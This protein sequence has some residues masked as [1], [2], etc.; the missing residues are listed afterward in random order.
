MIVYAVICRAKDATVLAEHS[1]DS[2]M[3]GNGP[4]VTIALLQHLKDHPDIVKDGELKTFVHNNEEGVE[5]FF[6][7]FL[8]VC[9]MNFEDDILDEYYFHLFLKDGVFYCCISDDPDTR[10]QKVN[11]A[12][13]QQIHTEFA[14]ANRLRRISN[15]NAYAMDKSFAPNFRTAL[16]YY[17]V[18][19][20]KLCQEEK[21]C[22]ILAQVEDMKDVMGRNIQ[23]SMQRA[24]NLEKMLKKSEEMEVETQVFYKKSKVNK[25]R[26]QRKYWR[27]YTTIGFIGVAIAYLLLVCVCGWKLDCKAKLG[28]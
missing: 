6:S 7:E 8:N 14:K 19:H 20:S 2:L 11:F 28:N 27:V 1:S 3:S 5:D 18:N 21:V 4:Q 23:L 24:G 25:K 12:F 13:L 16:H 26:Q 22:K 17:N 10:D 15:A 9:A